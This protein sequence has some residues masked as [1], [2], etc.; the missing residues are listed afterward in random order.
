MIRTSYIPLIIAALL[1][2]KT[3][4]YGQNVRIS[5]IVRDASNGERLVG[6]NVY[7]QKTLKGTTTDENGYFSLV[8][9][10]PSSLVFSYIGY[11]TKLFSHK[12]LKD[13]LLNASLNPG[14]LLG[15]VIVRADKFN[16]TDLLALDDELLSKQISVFG[17]PDIVKS[18]QQMPGISGTAEGSSLLLV[19]GGTPG[20]NAYLIDQAPL[21]YVNHV[22]GFVSVFNPEIISHLELFKGNF[23]SRYGGKLSSVLN[24]THREGNNKQRKGSM[25]LGLLDASLTLEGPVSKKSTIIFSTRKSVYDLFLLAATAATDLTNN[26]N[27]FGFYDINTKFSK[28]LSPRTSL[29]TT[30]YAGND[31]FVSLSKTD[32]FKPNNKYSFKSNW[33]NKLIALT[34]KHYFNSG[35]FSATTLSANDYGITEKLNSRQQFV[36]QIE[37]FESHYQSGN[38]SLA[39]SSDW[40][41]KATD[42][43]NFIAG[44]NGGMDRFRPGEY[45]T[46]EGLS[47]GTSP[48]LT[49]ENSLYSGSEIELLNRFRFSAGARATFFSNNSYNS[50]KAEPRLSLTMISGVK[51][52][53][54]VSYMRVHQ[55]RHLLFANGNI[56]T[57]EIWI[58][59]D[60]MAKPAVSDQFSAT[61]LFRLPEI[62]FRSE[63]SLYHKI[64]ENLTTYKE[65]LSH[66]KGSAFYHSK[67]VS[68]G[69]GKSKGIELMLS[70]KSKRF[71]AGLSYTYSQTKRR[72]PGINRGESYPFEFDRPFDLNLKISFDINRTWSITANWLFQS[73]LPYTPV[74]G[75]YLGSTGDPE[76]LMQV[77]VY[78][79]KNSAR[80]KDHHRLD[81][82]FTRQ[83]YDL[84]GNPRSVW[85]FGL[86]NA[87]NRRNPSYYFYLD[88]T[89]VNIVYPNYQGQRP[90]IPAMW[91]MSI[92]PI[93][94]VIAYKF[95]FNISKPL[96]N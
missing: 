95:Y 7:D 60:N 29:H 55:F 37:A 12:T 48:I 56:L 43:L 32:P 10:P 9:E 61:W 21:I 73:G 44:I 26:K 75:R 76:M 74:I 4:L 77:L 96:K 11:E 41:W 86:Y 94:P 89:T 22:G 67:I 87:Y 59:A 36:Q 93:M 30:I 91:Q 68:G 42:K 3:I 66:L 13:T 65:G 47:H 52:Q 79:P 69:F 70:K 57:N 62:G 88:E 64:S 45:R 17:K 8:V 20:E 33:G 14:F 18:L 83:K 1:I 63:L 54:N 53:F 16:K 40:S 81:I 72:F 78:G 85:T 46:S 15:E 5:G 84:S 50:F 71:E 2:F 6:A 19:R 80:M 90:V 28:I 58:P 25:H 92:F 39:Y 51:N 34:L 38:F 82:A 23:P 35:I 49:Y 27:A 31:F 24:I